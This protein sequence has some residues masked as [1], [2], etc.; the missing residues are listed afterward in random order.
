MSDETDA[1]DSLVGGAKSKTPLPVKQMGLERIKPNGKQN[2]QGGHQASVISA[3][4]QND[5]V[6]IIIDLINAGDDDR[7][8][9]LL[10][11]GIARLMGISIAI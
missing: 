7:N 3:D 6:G 5:T 9:H 4:P 2:L 11:A 10:D 8:T 1:I